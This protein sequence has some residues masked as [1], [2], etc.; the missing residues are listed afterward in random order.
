MSTPKLC[1]E[2][3]NAC[4]GYA[5]GWQMAPRSRGAD[6]VQAAAAAQPAAAPAPISATNTATNKLDS[7]QGVVT[8]PLK[9]FTPMLD[10]K[11][12]AAL[13]GLEKGSQFAPFACCCCQRE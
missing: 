1:L 13:F 9:G 5:F 8:F 10:L 7:K 4:A 12:R 3:L 11:G 2:P 6:A